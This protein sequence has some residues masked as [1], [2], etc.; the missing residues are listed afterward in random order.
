M[1][2]PAD[3][4]P[5]VTDDLKADPV[6]WP[7][8]EKMSEKD[9][10]SV[11]KAY[12]HSQH[13][14]GSAITLPKG[15]EEV[16]AWRTA[17]LPKLVQA[18]VLPTPPGS[19]DEYGVARP[20]DLPEGLGWNDELSKELAATLHKHGAP[21]ALAADLLALH[22]KALVGAQA[23]FKT[24]YDTGMAALK[25]EHGEHFAERHEAGR[26]LAAM[27]FKTPEEVEVF[28]RLGLGDHPGFLS[29]IMRL[30]PLAMQD[31]SFIRDMNRPGGGMGAEEVRA[32]LGKIMSDKTHPMHAGYWAKD[33]KVLAHIDDLYR[34]AYGDQKVVIGGVVTEPRPGA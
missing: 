16:E 14:L 8:L 12:A 17:H 15:P 34:K 33:P 10:P 3:L 24:S 11:L 7:I 30:A 2:L 5:F 29:V 13:R 21:K 6:A 9:A 25:A 4:Q 32:E 28:E 31:S 19:P 1:P 22:T 20:A 18:G 26:R 27:I 23:G